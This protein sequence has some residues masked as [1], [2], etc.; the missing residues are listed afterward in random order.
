MTSTTTGENG[1]SETP[2]M[3]SATHF[4][5]IFLTRTSE[6]IRIR[7]YG[8]LNRTQSIVSQ[9]SILSDSISVPSPEL[10]VISDWF[11]SHNHNDDN[12][13]DHDNGDSAVAMYDVR[14][15]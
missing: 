14:D 11:S 9:N 8:I 13:S 12:N 4:I 10:M 3:S 2:S 1:L 6:S 15:Y 7:L 5:N